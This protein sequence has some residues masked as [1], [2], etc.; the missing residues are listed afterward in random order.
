MIKNTILRILDNPITLLV[1]C[2][3]ALAYGFILLVLTRRSSYIARFVENWAVRFTLFCQSEAML[4]PFVHWS[5]LYLIVPPLNDKIAYL[6]LL[7]YVFLILAILPQI[8]ERTLKEYRT[9]FFRSFLANPFIWV[10]P[11]LAVISFFWSDTPSIALRSGLVLLGINLFCFYVSIRFDWNEV[12]SF[13]RWNISAIALL[14]LVIRR[15]TNDATTGGGG[16]AGI[17]PSKNSLGALMAL[18]V[19]LW[20]LDTLDHKKRRGI[21]FLMALICFVT[22]LQAKSAAAYLVLIILMAVTLSGLFLKLFEFRSVAILS[23]TLFL[24]TVLIS[25]LVSFNLEG[26]LGLFGKD[27]S[28]TGRNKIWPAILDAVA[29]RPWSGY[30]SFSFWQ[31]WR[32][33]ENPALAYLGSLY[34][35]PPSAHQGFLDVLLQFGIFGFVIFILGLGIALLQSMNFFF[36]GTGVLAVLPL[37]VILHHVVANIPE[38]RFLRPNIFWVSFLFVALKLSLTSFPR[39]V[40]E[41]DSPQ[42][43]QPALD[44][45]EL[46]PVPIQKL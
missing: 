10:M 46:M 29:Q 25:V 20:L 12:F 22:L 14:S 23:S 21:S 28:F 7:I 30:G 44:R 32:G 5:T 36:R 13:I 37:T 31:P 45:S 15:T 34:W 26:I 18:G 38:T 6:Q 1:V 2:L 17:L 27:L 3:M 24:L 39:S 4:T 33:S 9:L 35:T 40:T 19:A 42:G 41:G 11:V 16:L 8:R 43:Q